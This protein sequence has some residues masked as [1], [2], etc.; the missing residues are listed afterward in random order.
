MV[1]L[2]HQNNTEKSPVPHPNKVSFP[3]LLHHDGGPKS[4]EAGVA[5]RW[6]AAGAQRFIGD[7]EQ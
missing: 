3:I 6:I 5:G 4:V 7:E 2:H 1:G